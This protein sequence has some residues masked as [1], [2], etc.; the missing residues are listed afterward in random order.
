MK[1]SLLGHWLVPPPLRLPLVQRA[2]PIRSFLIYHHL[3]GAPFVSDLAFAAGL[4][5]II[6]N[7]DFMAKQNPSTM[8]SGFTTLLL[9]LS[10]IL[11]SVHGHGL[12][13][14]VTGAN[15][16]TGTGFGVDASTPRDGSGRKPFQVR[17]P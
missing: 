14:A 1:S 5:G 15:G 3:P 11:P 12:I 7:C 8:Y 13:T 2:L 17:P 9:L 16:V 10:T 6:D 4:V